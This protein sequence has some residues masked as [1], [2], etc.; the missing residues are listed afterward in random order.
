MARSSRPGHRRDAYQVFA[1]GDLGAL[2]AVLWPLS[3]RRR[4]CPRDL[5]F[6]LFIGVMATVTADTWKTTELGAEPPPAAPYHQRPD[7]R[8]GH[9]G[10]GL[11]AGH[12]RVVRRR[13]AHR[14]TAGLL[15]PVAGLLPWSAAT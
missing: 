10:R 11:A 5:W 9:V 13:A 6:F 7:G 3:Y 15:A 4:S 8:S 14:L 2:I 1:N 12:G